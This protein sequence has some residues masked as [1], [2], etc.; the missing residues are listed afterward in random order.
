MVIS[1]TVRKMIII[2]AVTGLII[3]VG[4]IV[5]FF[6]TAADVIYAEGV[7]ALSPATMAVYFTFGVISTTLLNIVKTIW[8]EQAVEKATHISESTKA[9]NYVR[10]QYFFRFLLTGVVLV[11]AAQIPVIQFFWGAVFGVFT[12][13]PAKYSLGALAKDEIKKEIPAKEG[14]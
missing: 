11:G 12:F 2:M 9:A 10:K 6:V 1:Q 4:G 8:L 5:Y 13:H 14:E 7:V 3:I